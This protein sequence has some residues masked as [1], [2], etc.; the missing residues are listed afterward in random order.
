MEVDMPDM[1]TLRF[2]KFSR[3]I[4]AADGNGFLKVLG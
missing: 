3:K 2:A 1:S 4:I